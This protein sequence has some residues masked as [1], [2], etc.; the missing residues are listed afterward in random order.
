MGDFK[1]LIETLEADPS[2]VRKL[3]DILKILDEGRWNELRQ[4]VESS[5]LV[6][7]R[8]R[9][10]MCP[11]PDGVLLLLFQCHQG[12]IDFASPLGLYSP[13]RP[14]SAQ[15]VYAPTFSRPHCSASLVHLI[16]C[17]PLRLHTWQ[18]RHSARRRI[19]VHTG[20][21]AA[22]RQ[23]HDGGVARGARRAHVDATVAP[24]LVHHH[25]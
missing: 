16:R 4:T 1:H 20:C 11:A 24:R 13:Q 21:G 3:R 12:R 15:Y 25:V 22:P 9:A 19:Q 2:L 8:V 6:D 7:N 23:P 5:V 14:G 17:P 10:F 18:P